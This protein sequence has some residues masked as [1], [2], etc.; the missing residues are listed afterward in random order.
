MFYC[1]GC[2]SFAPFSSARSFLL[3]LRLQSIRGLQITGL[4]QN[5]IRAICQTP[6]GYLW[7]AT[8]DGLCPLRWRSIHHVQPKQYAGH[9]GQPVPLA[10]LHADGDVCAGTELGGVAQYHRDR[11]TTYMMR[12]GLPSNEATGVS[13]DRPGNLWVLANGSIT[14]W[15]AAKGPIYRLHGGRT[16]VFGF[17]ESGRAGWILGNR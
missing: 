9:Q 10:V 6:D 12:D 17:L 8:F 11:F 5:I 1:C 4:P 2:S 16:Q 15:H 3:R 13:G 14:R 7:L